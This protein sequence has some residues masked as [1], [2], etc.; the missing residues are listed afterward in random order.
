MAR[1]IDWWQQ[2]TSELER[3]KL[4]KGCVE[5]YMRSAQTQNRTSYDEHYP[6]LCDLIQRA[7]E[8][9]KGTDA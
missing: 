3:L 2:H 4:L 9:H 6:L 5:S 8:H 7:V 1:Y